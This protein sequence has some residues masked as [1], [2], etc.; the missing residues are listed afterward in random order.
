M[1]STYTYCDDDAQH[2]EKTKV[3]SLTPNQFHKLCPGQVDG[4][5]SF[6]QPRCGDGSNYSFFIT[7]P[8]TGRSN[9]RKILI[10]FMGGGACWDSDTCN[11][12][13]QY[14]AFPNSFDALVGM[15]CSEIEYGFVSQGRQLSML[16]AKTI[17][18]TDFR[19]YNTIVI[20]YCTQ[21]VHIGDSTNVSYNDNDGSS[22]I[23]HH[24]GAHNM[25]RTLQ[26]VYKNFPTPT[27]IFLTGCS[28]GGTAIP[29]AYD[30]IN[31]HYNKGGL[32]LVNI[33]AIM[34][35]SVYLTPSYF[36]H[37]GYPNWNAGSVMTTIGINYEKL[38][39]D[40]AYPDIV[41]DHVLKRGSNSDRWGFVTHT[42]DPVS[43]MYYQYM[44]GNNYGNDNGGNDNNDDLETQW[45]TNIGTSME[46]ITKRH[47]NV[48][49]YIINSE[50][51]CSFGLYY[52][53]Q[54]E[55]FNNWA[56]SIVK[57]DMALRP[58][59][60]AF[61]A[62]IT[63]G[64]IL[65]SSTL[66]FNRRHF[67]K[68]DSLIDS[69]TKLNVASATASGRHVGYIVD[70]VD[71]AMRPIT[72]RCCICPW[73]AG[74][75]LTT[76]I[77]FVIMLSS[78]GFAH[79]LDNPTVGPSAV[80]LSEY[81]INN[82]AL[83]IYRMEHYRL[84]TATFVY[85][86]VT[87]FLLCAYALYKTGLEAAMSTSNN[88]H[89][90]FLL[91]ASMLS[92]AI[93]L[94]YACIGNGASCSSLALVLGL[95]VVST[96]LHRSSD[97]YSSPLCLTAVI[98]VLGCTPIFPFDSV[99]V[100]TT[101]VGVGILIGLMVFV[102]ENAGKMSCIEHKSNATDKIQSTTKMSMKIRWLFVHGMMFVFFLL[103]I[104]L[105]FRVP[106]PNTSNI[107]PYLTG[108]NLVYS[109]QI[110]DFVNSYA[111]GDNRALE[112][113]NEDQDNMCAQLCI[114]HLI[115]QPV[116]WVSR[117]IQQLEKGTCE[118]NGFNTYIADKTYEKYSVVLEVQLFTV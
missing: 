67:T 90:H 23:V 37:N 39:Y 79:P 102:D 42:T 58:S 65:I 7:R 74:Y 77:Y 25:L 81:G 84:L 99:I 32:R 28:A 96:V 51:H 13:Q 104:L 113:R 36:L 106:S 117:F 12:Q 88:P 68:T 70:K 40:E 31:K 89:W 93:N 35:S 114:P 107:S 72:T 48:N 95:N 46:Y 49:T 53:L 100:L 43:L 6:G 110:D 94:I 21:D 2:A 111:S 86:G 38:K 118:D 76:T 91:I 57:E 41:W 87:T 8:T 9:D 29:I 27:H 115:Y 75:I 44:S 64:G 20:P 11:M 69:E 101:S 34:D 59:V 22:S 18:G 16:C 103:Y 33:N 5:S 19:E 62:C 60:L 109:D 85:S 83:I 26:W 73:T 56:A 1:P 97:I 112:E 105:L 30:L 4:A 15:S 71:S 82:P 10:E 45:S 66:R 98:F 80:G 108:C 55:G 47:N 116:L 50:G 92:M 14:L 17:G 78:Q 61:I 24:V 63:F 52:P 3:S 54:E